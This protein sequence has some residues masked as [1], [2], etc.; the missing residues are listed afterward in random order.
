[1][2][3][4]RDSNSSIW[5]TFTVVKQF[6]ERQRRDKRFPH[7]PRHNGTIEVWSY[8]HGKKQNKKKHCDDMKGE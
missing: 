5:W 6:K 7:E 1:M 3:Y 4:N 2:L 8:A